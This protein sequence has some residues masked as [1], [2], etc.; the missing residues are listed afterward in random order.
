M[1]VFGQGLSGH[2]FRHHCQFCDIM[3]GSFS[4]SQSRRVTNRMAGVQPAI[5]TFLKV[6]EIRR[7]VAV[8]RQRTLVCGQSLRKVSS[9]T[10]QARQS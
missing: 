10:I 5:M 7:P 6:I 2:R 8:S 1:D 9:V 4:F 3:H